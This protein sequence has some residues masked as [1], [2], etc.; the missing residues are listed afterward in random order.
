[1]PAQPQAHLNVFEEEEDELDD[2][3][4]LDEDEEMR[5]AD[6]A[7]VE[8]E[9]PARQTSALASI[10]RPPY[11]I[12]QNYD[13]DTAKEVAMSNKKWL[14]V[15]I[16]KIDEFACMV[17]NRDL[18]SHED[19]KKVISENFIFVQVCQYCSIA[20][21]PFF[22]FGSNNLFSIT[23]TQMMVRNTNSIIHLLD[24]LMF[25]FSIP[26]LVSSSKPGQIFQEP[27][28]LLKI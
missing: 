3:N 18:W 17:L 22:Y 19:I 5:T 15:N 13:F 7:A 26:E 28:F 12:I 1:M 23:M 27:T 10:Y 21:F 4:D 6:E 14:L 24:T 16:Q 2:N 9:R 8:Y 20:S 11:D 25:L